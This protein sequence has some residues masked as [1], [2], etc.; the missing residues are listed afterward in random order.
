MNRTA[1][2]INPGAQ[3][4]GPE[5]VIFEVRS[6][7]TDPDGTLRFT[8]TDGSITLDHVASPDEI[9]EVPTPDRPSWHETPILSFH[10]N[11][12]ELWTQKK[13][14]LALSTDDRLTEQEQT[15]MEG[16]VNLIDAVQDKAEED[17]I[18]KEEVRWYL[19]PE[20]RAAEGIDG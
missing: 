17:G 8:V 10:I 19:R 11:Y 18:P 6:R 3:I 9:I 7:T 4:V 2:S 14:L 15:A 20:N 12:E 1:R 13:I 5:S 16:L